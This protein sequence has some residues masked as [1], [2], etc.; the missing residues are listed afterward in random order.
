MNKGRIGWLRRLKGGTLALLAVLA[1][2]TGTAWAEDVN[3]DA[4]TLSAASAIL[5]DAASG[6][7][8]Y[9]LNAQEERL[10]ASTTKIMTA[11]V[12]LE[13]GIDL[14]QVV[15]IT[16][17][18]AN[19]EGSSMYFVTGDQLTIRALLYGLMLCSGNDA[20]TALAVA[21]AGSEEAFVVWMNNKA[22][23]LGMSHT[24]FANPHGLDAE[25]HYST[26]EDMAKLMIY[27][28]QNEE[29][30]KITGTRYIEMEGFS[31]TNHN[32]LLRMY[33]YCIGGKN[34]YTQASGRTLVTCAEKDGQ[35]LVAVTL[36]DQDYWDDQIAMYNYGFSHWPTVTLCS[37]G[38]TI[39][40]LPIS[41]S[42]ETAPVVALES[43]FYPLSESDK[44]D[45]VLTLP[46]EVSGPVRMG[47]VVGQLSFYING[48]LYG[49]TYLVFGET[50][51]EA[52]A[53]WNSGF[54][55]S[56][57][58]GEFFLGGL[59]KRTFLRAG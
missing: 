50:I 18:F 6:R 7:V 12:V 59:L 51:E 16:D 57:P 20:A 34:G 38:Q 30:V 2:L 15:E 49:S 46:K 27:A 25:G 53:T 45:T 33:E 23:E 29:F 1:L 5:V 40:R 54:R 26:A 3:A 22:S 32:K 39:A 47:A 48:E 52:N 4:L 36:C 24:S 28:M 35:R 31:M 56:Y 8:L 10:I 13:C 55:S 19:V 37:V 42:S 17:E 11:I 21:C 14:D 43:V 9:S 44:L 41:G 58:P